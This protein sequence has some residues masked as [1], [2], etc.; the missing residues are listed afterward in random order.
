MSWVGPATVEA[1][2]EQGRLLVGGGGAEFNWLSRGT[3]G[4]GR[5]LQAR[6]AGGIAFLWR[7]LLFC[8][9][10]LGWVAMVLPWVVYTLLRRSYSSGTFFFLCPARGWDLVTFG[11]SSTFGV[12][13]GSNECYNTYKIQHTFWVQSRDPEGS[14]LSMALILYITGKQF[15]GDVGRETDSGNTRARRPFPPKRQP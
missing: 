10:W 1:E 14:C 12:S 9:R 7:E 13:I 2:G 11:V 4:T 8:R 3:D 6:T 15:N 5:I